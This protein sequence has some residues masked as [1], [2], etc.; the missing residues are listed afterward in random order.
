ADVVVELEHPEG[1]A[2]LVPPE[3]GGRKLLHEVPG[4]IERVGAIEHPKVVALAPDDLLP[5]GTHTERQVAKREIDVGLA[6]RVLELVGVP[7][8]P[9]D[10]A[11]GEGGAGK[12]AHLARELVD[13]LPAVGASV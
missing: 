13:G 9:R 6:Q 5:A 11:H 8:A 3:G 12:P 10:A 4:E 2:Q 7:R 1:P